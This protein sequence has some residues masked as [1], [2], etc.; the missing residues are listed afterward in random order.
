MKQRLERICS[1]NPEN[2]GATT[3][4][5]YRF[6]YL[7][8]SSVDKG[9][10]CWNQV[11]RYKFTEAPSRARRQIRE[12][13]VLLCT[14]RPGLQAHARICKEEDRIPLVASTGFA[15]LRP[16]SQEDSSFIFHQIFSNDVVAQ[17]RAKEVGSNYPAVN[18]SD[19]RRLSIFMPEPLQRQA[20]GFV[21]DTI[22]EAI[23]KT[24]AVIEKLK[25]VRAGMLHDLLTYGLDEHGQLRD[26]I[27]HLEE[28]K[29]SPLGRIPKVWKLEALGFRL[30]NN[31][32]S[33]QTGPFGSQLH[34]NE[35]TT[36]GIP[37]VM[38]QNINDGEFN[39]SNIAKIPLFRAEGLRRH[40]MVPGDLIFAR[41]GDLSRCAVVGLEQSG[42]LCGTG[43]LLMRF[44]QMTLNSCWLSQ[45]YRYEVCQR[46]IACSAVGTT[47]VN[48]NTKI[49]EDLLLPFPLFEEQE[50]IV[51]HLKK[52][53]SLIYKEIQTE[54][55]LKSLKL[56]LQDDLLTGRVRV[57]E[58]IMEGAAAV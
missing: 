33:I 15:V 36:D 16:N 28:F 7:D 53:D 29:D 52:H 32:G 18:E 13:D 5:E 1:A 4:Q 57:P 58:S 19:V 41:R 8:I 24:E 49:L 31:S 40:R 10:I 35:Y 34:A 9:R 22:D 42:W 25:Q 46:Q 26:P 3:P 56:G 6:K 45:A 51:A 12:G 21:L 17:L 27:A 44:K 55:T 20:V 38:P 37:V 48:L 50:A 43:C 14:V 47:M 11:N 54:D 39:K 2:L 23:A 30:K